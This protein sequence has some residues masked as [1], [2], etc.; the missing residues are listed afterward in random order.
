MPIFQG[1]IR[2]V[3]SQRFFTSM[4]HPAKVETRVEGGK[5]RN[6]KVPSGARPLQMTAYSAYIE[7]TSVNT[8]QF[9]VFPIPLSAKQ[10]R[11]QLLNMDKYDS[12]FGDL[13]LLF[14][15]RERSR[16]EDGKEPDPLGTDRM[17]IRAH[18]ICRAIHEL[19]Q[20]ISND[21]IGALENFYSKDYAFLLIEFTTP[22]IDGRE[23]VVTGGWLGPIAYVH[24]IIGVNG[25]P[26]LYLPTRHY[27]KH[28]DPW[29]DKYTYKESDLKH[30][31]PF[32]A[33]LGTLS[34]NDDRMMEIHQRRRAPIELMPLPRGGKTPIA[35][36]V[37]SR[38]AITA[39]LENYWDH[40]IYVV[41]LPRVCNNALFSGS[42]VNVDAAKPDRM[43]HVRVYIDPQKMPREI[44]HG[45]IASAHKIGINSSYKYR[46]DLW[47]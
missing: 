6:F 38:P 23:T 34:G 1:Q 24:E 32:D 43:R 19:Y 7:V 46:L 44:C 20:F 33:E 40:R 31:N 21:T 16:L 8:P 29:V 37:A 13:E 41:N 17:V 11:V 47:L 22:P 28:D 45:Q 30:D 39:S 14:P 35:A 27:L 26:K 42:G 9:A 36:V 12:L 5:K 4:V 10:N 18:K 2:D 15:L 3:R 25:R